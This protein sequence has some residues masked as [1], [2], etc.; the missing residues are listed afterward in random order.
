MPKKNV[1]DLCGHVEVCVRLTNVAKRHG[2]CEIKM[3]LRVGLSLIHVKRH[4]GGL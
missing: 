1:N 4:H 3:R 2:R